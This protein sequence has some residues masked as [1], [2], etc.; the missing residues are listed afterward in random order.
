MATYG[1]PRVKGST[2]R[3]LAASLPWNDDFV[4][5]ELTVEERGVRM[6][7][8]EM[9]AVE[10]GSREY[11]LELR[12]EAEQETPQIWVR[13]VC[14]QEPYSAPRVISITPYRIVSI[15]EPT[16][17]NLHVFTYELSDIHSQ[18]ARSGQL[19]FA[20]FLGLISRDQGVHEIKGCM[21]AV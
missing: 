18:Q 20:H 8:A 21:R 15:I 5:G 1:R 12:V 7:P 3:S 17:T 19:L 4:V 9:Q 14:K 13:R 6:D 16:G 2:C 11:A 10:N